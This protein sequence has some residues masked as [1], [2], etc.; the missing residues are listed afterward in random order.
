LPDSAHPAK[1]TGTESGVLSDTERLPDQLKS[2]I[3]ELA[4]VNLQVVGML[5]A[6]ADNIPAELSLVIRT[7][8]VFPGD[9]LIYSGL[10]S[11]RCSEMFAAIQH[12]N[13]GLLLRAVGKRGA[14][15][16]VSRPFDATA[17]RCLLEAA[18]A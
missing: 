8:E 9:E 13:H 17:L 14:V 3:R 6:A 12:T 18:S 5:D 10:V 2:T 1:S 15:A 16:V 7:A 11:S 4:L